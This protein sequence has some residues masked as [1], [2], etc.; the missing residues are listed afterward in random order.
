MD[1]NQLED[2]IDQEQCVQCQRNGKGYFDFRF[3]AQI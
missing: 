1:I 3:H 2:K